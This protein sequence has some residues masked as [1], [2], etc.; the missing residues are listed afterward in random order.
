M[1]G[2]RRANQEVFSSEGPAHQLADPLKLVELLAGRVWYVVVPGLPAALE[3]GI[4]EVL[5]PLG[6]G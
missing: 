2:V 1:R 5:V 4:K 3:Q 6:G